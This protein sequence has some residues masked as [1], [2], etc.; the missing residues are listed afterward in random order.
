MSMEGL[1]AY[2]PSGARAGTRPAAA[3]LGRGAFSLLASAS[4][5][6]LV[7]LMA[8]ERPDVGTLARRAGLAIPTTSQHLAKL[9]MAKVVAARREGQHTCYSV[10]DPHMLAIIDEIFNHIAPRRLGCTRPVAEP[11]TASPIPYRRFCTTRSRRPWTPPRIHA[12]VANHVIP[13]S[14]RPKYG[15]TLNTARTGRS[16]R[17]DHGE[18]AIASRCIVGR[19][20]EWPHSDPGYRPLSVMTSCTSMVTV[21]LT[22]MLCADTAGG[23]NA[24]QPPGEPTARAWPGRPDQRRAARRAHTGSDEASPRRVPALLAHQSLRPP[25]RRS[26]C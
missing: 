8:H 11:D 16:L 12:V 19:E 6:H 17:L 13:A 14:R 21:R 3:A 7:W 5:L 18:L 20:A 1:P 15:G 23:G 9:R 22:T 25:T 2:S 24:V 26:A 4:R 10:E